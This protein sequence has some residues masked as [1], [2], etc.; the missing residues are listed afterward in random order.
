MPLIDKPLNFFREVRQEMAKV[1]WPT[2]E[3]LKGATVV[4]ISFSILFAIYT[5]LADRGLQYLVKSLLELPYK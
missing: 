4:V 5:F 3:E 2:R 1:S